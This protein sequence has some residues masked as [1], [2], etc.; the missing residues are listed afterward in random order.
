[1]ESKQSKIKYVVMNYENGMPTDHRVEYRHAKCRYYRKSDCLPLTVAE[2]IVNAKYC[3]R[4]PYRDVEYIANA[5]E[6]IPNCIRKFFKDN[7]I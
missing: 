4:S 6:D 7:T 2:F 5:L 3:I 1:M